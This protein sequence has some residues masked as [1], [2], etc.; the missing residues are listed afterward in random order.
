MSLGTCASK[1]WGMEPNPERSRGELGGAGFP[2]RGKRSPLEPDSDAV[3]PPSPVGLNAP[4]S[5]IDFSTLAGFSDARLPVTSVAS[6][7]S[8]IS[9]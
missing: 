7:E 8:A 2:V 4:A 3:L 6:Y 1:R 5:G 9:G